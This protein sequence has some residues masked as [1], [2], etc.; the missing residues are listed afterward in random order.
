MNSDE[1]NSLSR[2]ALERSLAR[3]DHIAQLLSAPGNPDLYP[4]REKVL[5][6]ADELYDFIEEYNEKT[7]CSR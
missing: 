2:I 1:T 7:G 5:K 6:L 3:L 4:V